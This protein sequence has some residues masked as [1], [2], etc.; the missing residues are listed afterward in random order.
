MR[1]PLWLAP[2]RYLTLANIISAGFGFLG[3]MYQARVLGPERL[4]VMAVITGLT[5][6]AATL[7]DVRLNDVAAKAF[8][9]VDGL[10]PEQAP[11]YRAGVLWLALL[12]ALLVAGTSA[13][14]ASLVGGFLIPVFTTAPVEGWWLPASALALALSITSGALFYLL[15]FSREF[16][17]IGNWRIIVQLLNVLIT[18]LLLT[19][20]P[21]LTGAYLADLAGGGLGL[22]VVLGVSWALWTRRFALPLARPDWRRAYAVYRQNLGMIFYGNLLGYSKLLQRA[23]DVLVVAY[24]T[25][26]R[27]TGLYK[28]ARQVVDN[29]LAILQDA[30]YQ[31]YFPNFLE[32]FAR[33][34][35]QA[36]CALALRLLTLSAL[37]TIAL[38]A[39][40]ALL[41]PFLVPLLFGPQFAGAEW[42][43]MILTATFV[44][45]VGFYTWLWALFT[46]SGQ[47]RGYTA[48]TF[49]SVLVQ[50]G[51]MLILFAW[52]SPSAWA[53][54][55]GMLAYYLILM[56]GAY[57]LAHRRWRAYLPGASRLPE[58]TPA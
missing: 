46:G 50:Y 7:I 42:P 5:T 53:A 24:F 49:L 14:L 27:E 18:L 17:S 43:M 57:G 1:P 37:I 11:A 52:I 45:I 39:G 36:F 20:L 55:L 21:N 34:A 54:M 51:V 15:R 16:Y 38:L 22:L 26:D 29:G 35:A 10:A 48:L 9:Q 47:L 44:F 31:V 28:L 41:L 3:A 40:E 33:R 2:T 19:A 58:V 6:S 8:Y 13:L 4:G 25:S 23:L 32:L 30:L 12:G 56:P